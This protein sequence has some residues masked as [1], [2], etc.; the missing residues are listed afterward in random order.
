MAVILSDVFKKTQFNENL[1]NRQQTDV[2]KVEIDQITST[3]IVVGGGDTQ[4]YTLIT[5]PAG[6]LVDDVFANVNAINGGALTFTITDGS[7]AIHAGTFDANVLGG[8]VNVATTRVFNADTVLRVV[9]PNSAVIKPAL[10]LEVGIGLKR[11]TWML[12]S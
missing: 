2:G 6:T 3:D 5:V 11:L 10:K 1:A 12:N 8:S 9:F 4:E 7:S